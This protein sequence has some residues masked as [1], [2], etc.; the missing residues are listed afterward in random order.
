MPKQLLDEWLKEEITMTTTEG[1][2]GEECA[3]N[4]ATMCNTLKELGIRSS[5]DVNAE[6]DNMAKSKSSTWQQ[7][8][9]SIWRVLDM[10]H[11]QVVEKKSDN[12]C[13]KDARTTIV[14]GLKVADAIDDIRNREAQRQREGRDKKACVEILVTGSLYLVGSALEAVGWEEGEAEGRLRTL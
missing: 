4:Y 5:P 10:H 8:L 2:S 7:T 1:A 9:A 13:S 3:V 12:S 14:V 6:N 11:S